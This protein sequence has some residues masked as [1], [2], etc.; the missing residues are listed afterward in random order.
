MSKSLILYFSQNGTTARVAEFIAAGLSTA[1][2]QSDLYNIKDRQPPD[3]CE[4]DL[5]GIGSPVYY[6]KPPFN[7]MN[8]LNHLP[9]LGGLP[10]FVFV[11]HGTYR[12]DTGN[13][14]RIALALKG[15][16]EV[17][18][19]H[20]YGVDFFLAYLKEG[21]LFSPDHPTAEELAQAETFGREVADNVTSKLYTRPEDYQPI[22]PIYRLQRFLTNRWLTNH[23]YSRLISVNKN[24]CNA[25]GICVKL[26]PM[27]NITKDKSGRPIWGRNCI[28]CLTCEMNCSKDAIT[29]PVNWPIFHP[30]FVYNVNHGA[31]DPSLDYVNVV[32]SNGRTERM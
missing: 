3:P 4:Y 13:Q 20:S 32:H 8:Y 5:L 17:G 2:Y 1:G 15:A 29:S 11:L 22:S 28:L 16:R 19:F 10:F 26:C 27:G 21:Y 9:N 14:L 12:F 24:K 18:Y 7:V 23:I 25:C 6:F 30:F 31:R